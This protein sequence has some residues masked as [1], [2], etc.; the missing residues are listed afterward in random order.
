MKRLYLK[1][2]IL[3][4]A[5]FFAFSVNIYADG[6]GGNNLQKAT[7]KFSTNKM[8]TGIDPGGNPND[9]GTTPISAAN[10][11]LSP[12]GEG[13]EI[14]V[15]LGLV[16]GGYLVLRRRSKNSVIAGLTRNLLKTAPCHCVRA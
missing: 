1:S 8:N 5:F 2:I 14:L 15:C 3:S 6:F 4:I 10:N 11:D 16:Y 7:E 13:W 12:I 9:D